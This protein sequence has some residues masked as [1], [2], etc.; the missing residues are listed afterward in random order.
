VSTLELVKNGRVDVL[1]P[2]SSK[3]SMSSILTEFEKQ[4][5]KKTKK[6]KTM[7]NLGP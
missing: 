1:S 3:H 4:I 2:M 6:T 7:N 5:V